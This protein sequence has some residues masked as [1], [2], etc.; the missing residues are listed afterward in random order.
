MKIFRFLKKSLVIF[1][2]VCFLYPP[3]V[4]AVSISKKVRCELSPTFSASSGRKQY[5]EET[6]LGAPSGLF[7]R[8]SGSSRGLISD[9]KYFS[10]YSMP[11]EVKSFFWL[12]KIRGADGTKICSRLSK[13]SKKR[14]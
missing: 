4:K 10:K 14:R 13:N 12:S 9:L 3:K 5:W 7:R 11:E 2:A 1:M 8:G 6:A